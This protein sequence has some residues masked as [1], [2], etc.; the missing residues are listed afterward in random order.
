M[1]RNDVEAGCVR[2]MAGMRTRRGVALSYVKV[3]IRSRSP[4]L[5]GWGLHGASGDNL[6]QRSAAAY[7]CAEAAWAAG[8][9]ARALYEIAATASRAPAAIEEE[10]AF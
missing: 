7:G 3:E 9:A 4:R 5:W 1:V 8:Q 2:W 10:L 6:I